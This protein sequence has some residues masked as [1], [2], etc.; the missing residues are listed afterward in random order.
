VRID[1]AIHVIHVIV[2][3][4]AP[5]ASHPRELIVLESGAEATV[6]ITSVGLDDDAQTLSNHVVE[7]A[8]GA[9]SALALTEV[10]RGGAWR[11]GRT[12][13]RLE[14]D[15][16][17][18]THTFDLGGAWARRDIDVEL[19]APGADWNASGLYLTTDSQ[20][21]DNHL[22]AEHVAPHCSSTQLYKGVL[23]GASRAVFNGKVVVH[24]GAI[25]TDS[26]QANH[27]LLTSRDAEVDT[28]P[29]LE[30]Y[31]D[32]VK[33]AHGTTVGQLDTEALW[34]MQTRGIPEAQARDMLVGA[35]VQEVV[36]GVAD[37]AVAALVRD[38]VTTRIE[39]VR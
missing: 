21:L 17:L 35:F 31:N 11:I 1:G 39:V 18:T 26:V 16:R 9:N 4:D 6:A 32:D 15:A 5:R 27:N 36:D 20:H 2:G 38:A 25:K 37:P 29:E 8:L 23:A 3:S 14:R 33:C 30:I 19:A 13:A 10:V 22:R 24:K 34:Y 12:F 7:V 28:K